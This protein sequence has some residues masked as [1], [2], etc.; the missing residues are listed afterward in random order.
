MSWKHK[1]R[2]KVEDICLL[3]NCTLR[4]GEKTEIGNK[5]SQEKKREKWPVCVHANVCI[6]RKKNFSSKWFIYPWKKRT[7]G[8]F[9]RN[10]NVFVR[11][12]ARSETV[13]AFSNNGE[14]VLRKTM[15][16]KRKQWKNITD[17]PEIVATFCFTIIFLTFR[18][19]DL[20]FFKESPLIL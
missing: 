10:V 18:A 4:E 7:N 20:G 17:V 2:K 15:E 6:M 9:Y 14:V 3:S 19:S 16:K 1:E 12:R 13:R 5:I 8:C 11:R